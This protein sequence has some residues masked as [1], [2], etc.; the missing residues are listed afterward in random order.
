MMTVSAVIALQVLGGCAQSN[1]GP[2]LPQTSSIDNGSNAARPTDQKA[3]A[4]KIA[5]VLPLA[6]YG[7]SAQIAR[8]TD[9]HK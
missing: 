1:L 9:Y 7:E 4:A 5:L 8:G 3:H 2:E 6:G